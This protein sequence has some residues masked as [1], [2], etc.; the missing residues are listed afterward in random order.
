MDPKGSVMTYLADNLPP[1][2]R[3]QTQLPANQQAGS[4]FA[5]QNQAQQNQ[6][7]Q[8]YSSVSHSQPNGTVV[9]S[10]TTQSA[11]PNSVQS[12]HTLVQGMQ[13]CLASNLSRPTTPSM[14]QL[15]EHQPMGSTPVNPLQ[16]GPTASMDH[17]DLS[18][19]NTES[20]V[21]AQDPII[22]PDQQPLRGLGLNSP[23]TG[24]RKRIPLQSAQRVYHRL[25]LSFEGYKNAFF[26]AKSSE[27]TFSKSM[28]AF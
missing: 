14:Q 10:Q 4:S 17:T 13:P 8:P 6:N 21:P 16:V 19:Q 11:P 9:P 27:S 28:L 1:D 22:K 7:Q 24:P 3:P 26:L 12:Q 18:Q 2:H 5:P 25:I 23:P 15:G 20:Q